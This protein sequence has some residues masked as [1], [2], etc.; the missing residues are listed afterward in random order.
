MLCPQF[1]EDDNDVVGLNDVSVIGTI[2]PP[3]LSIGVKFDIT[4]IMI[5][6]LNMKRVLSGNTVDDQ[7][8]LMDFLG[9]CK[10]YKLPNMNKMLSDCGSFHS[11]W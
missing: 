6:L 5:K 10:D 4:S 8:H 1:Y 9:I 2:V 7:L 11:H 3:L